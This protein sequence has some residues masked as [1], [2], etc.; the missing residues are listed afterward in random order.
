MSSWQ[1]LMLFIY[2]VHYTHEL[3]GTTV[4]DHGPLGKAL[5]RKVTKAVTY[6]NWWPKQL[7]K[8]RGENLMGGG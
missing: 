8:G 7:N 4:K 1:N 3:L 2:T 5:C 6:W